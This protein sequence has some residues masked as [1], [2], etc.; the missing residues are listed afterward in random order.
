[1]VAFFLITCEAIEYAKLKA[2]GATTPEE[3]LLLKEWIEE[4]A[5]SKKYL[6]FINALFSFF[7]EK[8]DKDAPGIVTGK[9]GWNKHPF[10]PVQHCPLLTA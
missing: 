10:L 6:Q 5:G 1:M 8:R 7:I 4:N 9:K 2:K 3:D